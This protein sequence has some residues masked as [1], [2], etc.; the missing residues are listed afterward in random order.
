MATLSVSAKDYI[1]PIGGNLRTKSYKEEA[2]QTF[3]LGAVVICDSTDKDQVETAGADPTAAILGIALQDA[4]GTADT[5]ILV[6][7]AEP[8][9][10]FVARVQD[11]GTLA[12]GNLGTDYGMV[13]DS[14]NTIWR[15]DLS[16]TT[17]KNVTVTAFVDEVGDINGRVRFQFLAAARGLF[18]G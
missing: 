14:T 4:T 1:R 7:L 10:E 15:V 2:S 16:E 8:G 17:N 6:G 3:K 13:Y 9:V 18:K 12:V 11:A 5:P